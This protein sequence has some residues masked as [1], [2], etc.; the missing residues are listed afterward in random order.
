MG[1]EPQKKTSTLQVNL[2]TI[3]LTICVALSGWALK[4]I[5]D[6]KTQVAGEV[7]IVNAN[8]SAIMGINE[9]NKDQSEKLSDALRR[10]TVLETMQSDQKNKTN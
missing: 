6:L 4:S 8:S 1:P 3:L 10:I 9:V 7:P 5:E 2:N